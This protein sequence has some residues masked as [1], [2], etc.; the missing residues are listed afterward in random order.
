MASTLETLREIRDI[1]ASFPYSEPIKEWKEQGKKVIGWQCTYVPEEIIY[2]AGMLPIRVTGG[3]KELELEDANAYLYIN[4]C[5]SVR[6]CLQLGLE[7]QYDFLDGFVAGSTCDG[8]RRLADVWDRYL[9]T[10]VIYVLSVPRKSTERA[11]ELYRQEVLEFK[12]RLE[13]QFQVEIT[14]QAMR[15][16][17][18]VFNRTRELL[19]KLYDLRKLD[20][21]PISGA[22]TLEVLNAGFIMPKEQFNE[23]LERLLEEASTGDRAL[24]GEFRLMIIGSTLSN[25]EFIKTIED[26]GG[27]V[28]VDE[29]CTSTR[30]WWELVDTDPN[31]DPLEAISRRYLDNFPCSRMYP[32]E[33][34]FNKVMDLVKDFRVDGVISQIIRY[35]VPY[36]HDE[37]L[38]RERFEQRGI[39]VLEVDVEYGTPGTGQIRTRVQAFLEMLEGGRK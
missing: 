32:V 24:E 35:C 36:A 37:P 23:L 20:N 31:L 7:K 8:A 16:A 38:L 34:R 12:R 18:G 5:S 15:K 3:S 25:P 2:A 4:S 19:K 10:P 22:E 9:S 39:P 13:E 29:L 17:I 1:N 26:L 30:Y 6:S 14:D 21:P 27:L 33:N 11:H 28:V